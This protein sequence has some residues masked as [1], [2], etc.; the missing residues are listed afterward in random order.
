MN[1]EQAQTQTA[2][3]VLTSDVVAADELAKSMSQPGAQ[4]TRSQVLRMAIHRGIAQLV[5]ESKKKA[6]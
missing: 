5:A 6:R 4:I 2:L 3:R 1:D